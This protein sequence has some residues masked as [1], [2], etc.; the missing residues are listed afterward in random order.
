MSKFVLFPEYKQ[1]IQSITKY[2]VTYLNGGAGSGKSTFIKYIQKLVPNTLVL[3]PTGIAA[4]NVKGRTIHSF[5]KYPPSFL[6]R[7]K[8]RNCSVIAGYKLKTQMALIG[9]CMMY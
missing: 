1:A 3:A 9:I 5:F 2:S 4:V 6:T 7:K 8:L